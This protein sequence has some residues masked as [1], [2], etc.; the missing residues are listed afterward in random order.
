MILIAG[1]MAP[2]LAPAAAEPEDIIK[3][4]QASMKASGGH[5]AASAAILKGKVPFTGDLPGHAR[6]LE[7]LSHGT[8]SWFPPGSDFGK[9]KALE[10][11]WK[12]RAEF[13]K[14]ARTAEE[15]ARAF[16]KA[17]AGKDLKAAAAA[18]KDLGDACS[19]CH[20]KFR[21]KDE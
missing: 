1:L 14:A 19:A 10:P 2:A 15:K 17:A 20:K 11:V 16:A 9:T 8:V 4:R 5:M 18:H 3:Y 6:A 7:Q 12:E 21:K 13:E